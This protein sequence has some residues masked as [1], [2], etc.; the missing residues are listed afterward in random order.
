MDR[1]LE[2]QLA[3]A[4]KEIESLRLENQRL[5]LQLSKYSSELDD[6]KESTSTIEIAND[7]E[8]PPLGQVHFQSS[9][10]DKIVLFRSLFRGR[11]DVYPV[12]WTSKTGKAGYSPVCK[13]DRSPVCGKPRIKCS[14]CSLQAFEM[15]SDDIYARHLM[16]R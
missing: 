9:P 11:E 15:V 16:Q 4:L 14:D 8:Q 2:L 7:H 6:F 10:E 13:N 5:K 1:N 12:R 3:Q